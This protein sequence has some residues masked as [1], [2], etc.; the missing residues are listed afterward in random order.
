MSMMPFYF[1]AQDRRLFGVLHPAD[2]P[3]RAL[4]LMCPPL[5]HEHS[6]SYRF[7]SQLAGRLAGDGVA[8]LR[9]DYH[10]TGDS[11]GEDQEFSPDLALADIAAAAAELRTRAGD[12]PLILMGIRASA[13]LVFHAADLAGADALWL[14]QPVVDGCAYVQSLY[15]QDLAA[16]TSQFRYPLRSLPV[17]S[18][19]NELVGFRISPRF[20]SEMSSRCVVANGTQL[21]V[22]VVTGPATMPVPFANGIHHV[23][24]EAVT[25]WIDELDLRSVIHLRDAEPV[26]AS[27]LL[28][29][30]ACR[31]RVAHG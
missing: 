8:C 5:L 2:G 6:R 12:Q 29:L 22:A 14:W 7:F 27:L 28:E 30:P 20:R 13:P 10:G 18:E 21:P 19:G 4:V 31:P 11:E 16:R 1:R 25:D 26:V 23:L 24:P 3:P 9:F 15:A 17:P